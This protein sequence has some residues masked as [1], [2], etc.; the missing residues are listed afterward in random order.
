MAERTLSN[1]TVEVN[2][3]VIAI[4]PNSLSFKSGKG[5]TNI[6][7][8]SSGGDAI[9]LVRTENA[10]TKMSMVKFKLANTRTNIDLVADWMDEVIDGV[11]I[12]LSDGPLT[13]SFRQMFIISDPEVSLGADGELECEF[14][15]LPSL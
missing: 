13:K 8:Q 3:S 6:R 10:E 7:P 5:D 2:D 14:N 4:L 1:P 15:G 12:R 9:T 11:T